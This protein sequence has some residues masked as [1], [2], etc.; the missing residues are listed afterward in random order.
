VVAEAAVAARDAQ[1][2]APEPLD[3]AAVVVGAAAPGAPLL[4]PA[5]ADGK[6]VVAVAAAVVP[7]AP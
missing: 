1:S 7:D 4:V 6:Q 5:A 3:A 2:Q